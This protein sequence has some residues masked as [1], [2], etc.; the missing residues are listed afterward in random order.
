MTDLDQIREFLEAMRERHSEQID[1]VEL[2]NGTF[3]YLQSLVDAGD[4]ETLMFVI[5]LSYLM[6]VQT[7]FAVSQSD[8]LPDL[9]DTNGPLKA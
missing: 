2:P 1:N 6:G 3:E 7:G 8:E 9:P 4:T 5:K